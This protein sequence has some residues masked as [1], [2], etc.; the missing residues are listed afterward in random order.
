MNVQWIDRG[1]L[2][3]WPVINGLCRPIVH[4]EWIVLVHFIC[5]LQWVDWGLCIECGRCLLRDICYMASDW[6]FHCHKRCYF[7]ICFI[8]S[9]LCAAAIVCYS[10]CV[11][12]L[13]CATAIVMQSGVLCIY[14]V[15]YQMWVVEHR[16]VLREPPHCNRVTYLAN[17]N[18]ERALVLWKHWLAVWL[19]M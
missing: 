19:H 5:G 17:S 3:M 8:M 14:P 2:N 11:L 16:P 9:V 1:T 13:L 15:M 12:L 7:V 6:C 4:A 10:H 18:L